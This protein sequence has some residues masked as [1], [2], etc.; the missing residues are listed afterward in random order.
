V[1]S[2]V[3]PAPAGSVVVT[4]F[5]ADPTGT[6]DSA[7]AIRN[8][9]TTAGARGGWQTVYF[10]PGTYLLDDNDHAT[11]D[12]LLKHVTVNI[13]GAGASHTKLVEK[14]GTV[15]YPSLKRGK[16]VFEFSKMNNFYI[17]GLT[18]DSQT[19]NAG[20]TIDDLGN[21]STVQDITALG[22]R[23]G[24]GKPV[25]S[26][27]VFDLRV[28]ADCNPNPSNRRYGV[29]H[30]GNVI[31]HIVLDGR[32]IG[33]NADLDVSCQHGDTVS[34]IVDK[35]WGMAIYIDQNVKVNNFSFTPGGPNTVFRG[36]F[37]TDSSNVT[38]NGFTTKGE[39]G[40]ISSPG[41]PSSGISI[42]NEHM[43]APG[44]TLMIGDAKDV[45]ITG[46]VIDRLVVAPTNVLDGLSVRGSTV[47]AV[48]CRAKTA[49]LSALD[50][51]RC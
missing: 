44:Y 38:I 2:S 43:E 17:D 47:G 30:E 3:I 27:N 40:R 7:V 9:I 13:L 48:T 25:D 21:Y 1:T 11:H 8:A 22:A 19:W 32:G 51:V 45:T 24:S 26:T 31:N 41:Y 6:R 20:D 36:W 42:T 37:V 35:G 39:G 34:N 50:G 14:V 49:K 5:G 10:P 12:F 33:G 16:S 18:I 15:A 46:S 23:N 29:Y 28:V 4:S